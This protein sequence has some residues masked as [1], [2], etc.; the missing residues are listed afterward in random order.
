MTSRLEL[1]SQRQQGALLDET[2]TAASTD[3]HNN[4]SSTRPSTSQQPFTA[5]L[6]VPREALNLDV[7]LSKTA[8]A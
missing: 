7:R 3:Q 1:G 4:P 6:S 2:P 5:G 8:S